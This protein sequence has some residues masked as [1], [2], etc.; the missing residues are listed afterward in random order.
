MERVQ[1]QTQSM[2][3]EYQKMLPYTITLLRATEENEAAISHLYKYITESQPLQ[4][5]VSPTIFQAQW[6]PAV[7]I[8]KCVRDCQQEVT[9]VMKRIK[10]AWGWG[11]L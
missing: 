3:C 1:T 10:K 4:N 9:A 8:S 7:A 2:I 6:Q 5:V 11:M